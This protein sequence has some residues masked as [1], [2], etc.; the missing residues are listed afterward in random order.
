LRFT[1][2]DILVSGVCIFIKNVN[3]VV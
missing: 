1:A 2:N 3:I